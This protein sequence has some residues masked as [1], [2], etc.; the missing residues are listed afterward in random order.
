MPKH[1]WEGQDPLTFKFFDQAKGWP[2]GTGPYKLVSA[3]ESE[4][5]YVR[6]DD[7]WGAKTG[8]KPLPKPKKTDLDVSGTEEVRTAMAVDDKLDYA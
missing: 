8:W 5:S 6:N 2:I 4:I 1:I 7:W 3:N